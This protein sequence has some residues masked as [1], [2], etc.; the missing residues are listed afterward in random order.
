MKPDGGAET[1]KGSL[2]SRAIHVKGP[3]TCA[4]FD[5]RS[6]D[7]RPEAA[8]LADVRRILRV[9]EC[10]SVIEHARMTMQASLDP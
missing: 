6:P 8:V 5:D 1:T 3:A 9:P 2:T 7:L 10:H 4:C